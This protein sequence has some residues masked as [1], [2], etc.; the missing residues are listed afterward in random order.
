MTKVSAYHTSS[1][2]E[3]AHNREVFHDHD[4]CYHG[5]EIKSWNKVSG[6]AGRPRCSECVRLG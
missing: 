4:D 6:T 2:E 3:S 5:K 1:D